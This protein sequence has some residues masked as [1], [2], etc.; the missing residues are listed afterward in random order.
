MTWPNSLSTL[1]THDTKRSEDVRAR[2]NALSEMA[3]KWASFLQKAHELNAPFK[4]EGFPDRNE[5]Y[6]LYQILLGTWDLKGIGPTY[7]DKIASYMVKAAK[8]AKLYTSW[9]APNKAYEKALTDFVLQIL[10]P[11]HSFIGV[12]EDFVK[13]ISFA[14]YS[15]TLSQTLLKMTIPGIP[16]FYQGSERQLYTLVDPGNRQLVEY[17]ILEKTM[18]FDQKQKLIAK[19]LSF[20]RQN[21]HLFQQGNYIPIKSLGVQAA[22]AIAFYRK[23]K[24]KTILVAIG[25]YFNH[26]FW[27]DTCILVEPGEYRNIFTEEVLSLKEKVAVQELFKPASYCL[28]EKLS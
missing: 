12:L 1:T 14:S 11:A 2:L 6:H 20:R 16:D 19:T 24:E 15:N 23:T 5:E 18:D 13:E 26:L 3:I 27:E 7:R 21:A 8:E 10:A 28:L 9:V 4:T 17:S 22:R 25:R